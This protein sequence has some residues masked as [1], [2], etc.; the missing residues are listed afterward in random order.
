[1]K[2]RC[3]LVVVMAVMMGCGNG[4][5]EPSDKSGPDEK[6]APAAAASASGQ[7]SDDERAT[8]LRLARE[9]LVAVVGGRDIPKVDPA[10]L[11][12]VLRE[13]KGCF[14]T[15]NKG[16]KLR[17]CIGYILPNGPLYK[18][19]MENTRNAAL[20]DRRFRPVRPA[21]LSQI[22]IE[23]SVLTVPKPLA[24]TSFDDLLARLR[25]TVDG[26][27][28]R[29]RSRQSTFLPQV[30]KEIPDRKKFMTQL[31]KKAGLNLPDWA[32][33]PDDVKVLTYQAEVFGER[34]K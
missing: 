12:P 29:A 15:L 25:P 31:A 8:L 26:V 16:G 19:V 28:F 6:P 22:E 23:I 21:E 14:V 30:W 1:M 2:R 7:H 11:P 32:W 4:D 34:E 13:E 24:F 9:T 18:A 27:V 5:D 3:V 20:T 33:K 10:G 17:G